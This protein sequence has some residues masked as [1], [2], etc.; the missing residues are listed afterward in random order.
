MSIVIVLNECCKHVVAIVFCC[1]QLIP[2][3]KSYNCFLHCDA[4]ISKRYTVVLTRCQNWHKAK[5]SFLDTSIALLAKYL[6]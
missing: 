1:L 5:Q 4:S 6:M 3:Y 2:L